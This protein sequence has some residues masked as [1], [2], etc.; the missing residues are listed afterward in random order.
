V[1]SDFSDVVYNTIFSNDGT[2]LV[3]NST[4]KEI[5]VYDTVSV[6]ERNKK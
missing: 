2:S 5:I 6:F 4:G 3:V 1:L